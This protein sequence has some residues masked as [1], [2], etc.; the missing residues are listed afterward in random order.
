MAEDVACT[1][2]MRTQRIQQAIIRRSHRHE[3]QYPLIIG[4]V[5]S[6]QHFNAK[7][8]ECPGV[9]D[10]HVYPR[11]HHWTSAGE[12]EREAY[13]G[14][15][16]RDG[17]CDVRIG[18]PSLDLKFR[19]ELPLR[20]SFQ[21]GLNGLTSLLVDR[22]GH[23]AGIGESVFLQQ[24]DDAARAY[25]AGGDV[26]VDVAQYQVR[27]PNVRAQELEDERTRL[28]RLEQLDRR[29]G[30]ALLKHVARSGAHTRTADIGEMRA[31]ET[32]AND[33]LVEEDRPYHVDVIY[34]AGADPRIVR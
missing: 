32:I 31:R 16:H 21:L 27:H 18:L 11:P 23:C 30:E 10:R 26:G 12:V 28:T 24:F 3:I 25:I 4:N 6:G 22:L 1:G 14:N 7:I 8:A 20:Q 5:G 19:A 2:R 13:I 9:A 33:S 15:R 17:E 34:V 29:Q